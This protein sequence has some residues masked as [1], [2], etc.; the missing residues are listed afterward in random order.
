MTAHTGL[1]RGNDTLPVDNNGIDGFI[2]FR[3]APYGYRKDNALKH[4]NTYKVW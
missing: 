1:F 4:D 2:T 3:V